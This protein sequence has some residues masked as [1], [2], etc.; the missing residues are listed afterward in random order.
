MFLV[1]LKN[2]IMLACWLVVKKK[3][4]SVVVACC[5]ELC[6]PNYAEKKTSACSNIGMQFLPFSLE[7]KKDHT[8]LQW[9]S[10]NN[11]FLCCINARGWL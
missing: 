6:R 7:L 8:L 9:I 11:N 10:S 4:S 3:L 2:S 1:L 5:L